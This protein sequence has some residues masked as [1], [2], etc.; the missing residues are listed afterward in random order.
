MTL[1]VSIAAGA[2]PFG[3][4]LILRQRDNRVLAPDSTSRR[5]LVATLL[6]Q[7]ES[8]GLLGF[9]LG[10]DHA[11][12]LVRCGREA[13]GE[14][15]RRLEITLQG[16][17]PRCEGF[18]P[19]LITEIAGQ[20][21]LRSLIDYVID[22]D[23][24]HGANLDPLREGTV[25]P[26]LLGLRPGASAVVRRVLDELPRLRGRQLLH[27]LPAP[28]REVAHVDTLA[29][30]ACA[31]LLLANLDGRDARRALARRAAVA[32]AGNTDAS[33]LAAVLGIDARSVRRLRGAGDVPPA[34]IRAVRRWSGLL[35][36]VRADQGRG[37]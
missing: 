11:H 1:A 18:R 21:H 23:R 35:A 32:A 6:A 20:D 16:R 3:F 13:A 36:A 12:V 14:L 24:K 8:F 29:E 33:V 31:A 28:L 27:H 10:D 17:I 7:P 26:D 19:L 34:L 37:G 25:L 2:M 5:A 22:Q 30:A 9:G 4:Q 15:G